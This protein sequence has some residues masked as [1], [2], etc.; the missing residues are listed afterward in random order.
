MTDS[1]HSGSIVRNISLLDR[2]LPL[3]IFGAMVLGIGLGRAFPNLGAQL[4]TVK[5]DTV[6]LPIAVGLLWMMYPVLAK[7]RYGELGRMAGKGKLFA[8]S[9]VLNWVVGP[10]LMV[11][12]AWLFLPDMP[13]YRNGLILIGL[14]RCIAMV[15][16]WNMLARGSNELA[17]LLVA[18]NSVFQIF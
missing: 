7:V 17:A 5:L 14:A 13:H 4:D 18:L 8:T 2:F 12:L 3:W 15:L 10:L 1:T 16:V 9:L 6:S 11:A